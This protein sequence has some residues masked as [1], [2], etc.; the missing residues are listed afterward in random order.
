MTKQIKVKF[1]CVL[2]L[3]LCLISI[4]TGCKKTIL[5]DVNRDGIVNME[6]ATLV[7]QYDISNVSE[8]DARN[9]DMNKDGVIDSSDAFLI[10]KEWVNN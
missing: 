7:L 4:C 6:D 9:A 2:C 1:Y 5:G 3:I 8:I 10:M